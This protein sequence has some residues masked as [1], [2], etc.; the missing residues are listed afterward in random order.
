MVAASSLRA[1]AEQRGITLH[2]HVDF[3][4]DPT[5][6][7]QVVL[8]GSVA[9]DE[10][11]LA[12]PSA[13][14]LRS[15]LLPLRSRRLADSILGDAS[16]GFARLTLHLV[17]RWCQESETTVAADWEEYWSLV[18]ECA[19]DDLACSWPV[20]DL[21]ALCGSA[22]ALRAEAHAAEIASEFEQVCSSLSEAGVNVSVL[23]QHQFAWSKLCVQ[24]RGVDLGS[25]RGHALLPFIDMVNHAYGSS[26]NAHV[27]WEG[28]DDGEGQA[29]LR[30]I[31]P[32]QSGDEVLFCYDGNADYLDL[33]NRYG[34]FDS[35]CSAHAVEMPLTLE[36]LVDVTESAAQV[37]A[38]KT[39]FSC[40]TEEI[41]GVALCWVDARGFEF[42]L[43]RLLRCA[44]LDDEELGRLDI[45][46][47]QNDPWAAVSSHPIKAEQKALLSLQDI[48][49]RHLRG[50]TG[51]PSK[52]TRGETAAQLI[53]YERSLLET[54]L[55][56]LAERLAD[57]LHA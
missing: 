19:F 1:L 16:N 44:M 6:G 13:A 3:G 56:D 55:R 32:A 4:R 23:S 33:F 12:V 52:G 11:L 41:G 2:P 28:G 7:W 48:L 25:S 34:F 57:T 49:L 51:N 9:D 26:A 29:V 50:Y 8:T 17:L 40:L 10:V 37:K 30:A 36:E 21:A 38:L 31:R 24:T 47:E 42:P 45:T 39:L 5:K 18:P 15:V 43:M 27:R 53:S 54:R 14:C 22:V 35:T 46:A 20:G